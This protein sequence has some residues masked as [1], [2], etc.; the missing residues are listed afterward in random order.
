MRALIVTERFYP[1][2]GAAPSR[3]TNMAQGF[4]EKGVEVDVLTS[5]PNYPKGEIFLCLI[6]RKK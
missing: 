5:L 4:S 6:S 1:E 3:L 2:V